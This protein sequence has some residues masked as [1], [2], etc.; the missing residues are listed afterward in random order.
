MKKNLLSLILF[1]FIFSTLHAQ[2][3]VNP[4][5][6]FYTDALGWYLKG[7]VDSLP[8]LKPY[9]TE[10]IEKIL[11][12]VME[13]ESVS[14]S[15]RED[16]EVYYKRYFGRK[17]HFTAE[18][19]ISSHFD[20]TEDDE[21]SSARYEDNYELYSAKASLGGDVKVNPYFGFGYDFGIRGLNNNEL[22]SDRLPMYDGNREYHKMDDF[23]FKEGD[24]DFLLDLNANVTFGTERINGSVGYSRT[25]FG[26]DPASDI[27]LN[28]AAF[29]MPNA[30]VNFDAGIFEYTQFT[31][32]PVAQSQ[33]VENKYTWGKVFSFHSL[34]VPFFNRKLLLSY[35]ESCM[36]GEGF[37]PSYLL[38]VPWIIIGEVSG[39][40]ENVYAGLNLQYKPVKCVA[41]SADFMLHQLDAKSF[42]KL[43]WNDAAIRGAL[44]GGI[45]YTPADS[46][47]RFIKIDYSIVTPY[48]YTTY[49][50]SDKNYNYSD[51]TNYGKCLGSE[52]LPNSHQLSM[53]VQFRPVKRFSVTS[54]AKFMQHA[55][56]YENLDD[57]E[58]IA[59][60]GKTAS[61]GSLKQNIQ[62]FDTCKDET[63]LL[64]QDHKLTMVQSGI[65]LD[66]ECA[67]RKYMSVVLTAGYMFE[68]I[69]NK[70]VEQPLFPGVYSSADEVALARKRWEGNL[71]NSFNHYFKAGVKLSF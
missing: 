40:T 67:S 3:S 58:V 12:A 48:T 38:P 7:Y 41:L 10:V 63:G 47:F 24:V 39:H 17:I 36:Y 43:K 27:I 46:I 70:G 45:L 66:F 69:M 33:T 13:D 34:R 29:Q 25:G 57:E 23:Y 6:D 60:S 52:L 15:D 59:L 2:I 1:I 11:M 68:Y 21:D 53:T 9:S 71:H 37:N 5:S 61:D 20:M 31:G 19:N 62:G 22:L 55:N 18:G 35:Y 65:D 16:A 28:P 56:E 64:N 50:L 32:V 30:S 51:Y 44:K 54:T 42:I 14:E 8:Q 4:T 49:D 26:L